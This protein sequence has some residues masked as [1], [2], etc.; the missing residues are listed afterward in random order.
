MKFYYVS[1]TVFLA[2]DALGNTIHLFLIEL[3]AQ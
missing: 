2:E 1:R 3:T